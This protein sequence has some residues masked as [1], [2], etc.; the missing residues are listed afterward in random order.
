MDEQP[1]GSN[2]RL[3]P[4]IGAGRMGRVYLGRHV[5]GREFAVKKLRSDLSDDSG[6]IARFHQEWAILQKLEGPNL[7]RVHD[8]VV[9]GETVAFVMDLVPGGDL[10]QVLE[11]TGRLLPSEVARIGAGIARALAAAHARGVVHGDVKPEN[12]LMDSSTAERVPKLTDFGIATVV[13]SAGTRTST[14]R[15]GTV[16]YMAPETAA[17]GPASSTVD[18]YALGIVLY[19]LSCGVTPFASPSIP[20]TLMGHAQLLPGKP[21]GIAEELWAVIAQL[22]SKNPLARPDAGVVAGRLDELAM[23]LQQRNAPVAEHLVAPPPGRPIGNEAETLLPGAFPHATPPP[24][25]ARRSLMRKLRVAGVIVVVAAIAATGTYL[26]ASGSENEPGAAGPRDSGGVTG[27]KVTGPTT[28][29]TV[30]PTSTRVTQLSEMPDLVGK[31][32]G[33]ARDALPVDL[34]VAVDEAFDNTKPDGT[35]TKQ[36]PEPGAAVGKKVTLTAARPAYTVYLD[37]L[38]P[39]AGGWANTQGEIVGMV[40]KSYP[41]SLFD[42]VN[43]CSEKGS[44]EYNLS[45]GYRR[46]VATSGLSDDSSYADL[47]VQFEIFADEGRLLKTAVVK[48]GEVVDFDLDVTDVLRLKIQ[49]QPARSSKGCYSTNAWVLGNAKLLGV[50]GEVPTSG[51]PPTST[52]DSATTTTTTTR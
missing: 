49:W 13:A 21:P 43:T 30:T 44:V 35:V 31:L 41:H 15:V 27:T 29:T 26:F 3:G 50:A 24:P 14:S 12:V 6:I 36:D 37:S 10:R 23:V 16:E 48:F 7:V 47:N 46:F 34:E 33:D 2:Y 32:L 5:D 22:L 8:L 45:K 17:G 9:E 51:L 39:I 52:R 4:Q 18:V 1:L 40:G 11:A 25:P 42:R 20:Q 19:E 38:R 28:T